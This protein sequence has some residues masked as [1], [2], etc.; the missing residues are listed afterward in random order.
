[1]DTYKEVEEFNR[2]WNLNNKPWVVWDDYE[3]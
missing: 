3:V 1:M 2:Q